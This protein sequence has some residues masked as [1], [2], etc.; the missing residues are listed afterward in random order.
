MR[1]LVAVPN[2]QPAFEWGGPV[3][4]DWNLFRAVA[5]EGVQ[6]TVV[7]SN[8]RPYGRVQRPIRH[9][10]EGVDIWRLPVIG[11]GRLPFATR[12]NVMPLMPPVLGWAL[13]RADLTHV[14]AVWGP[15]P[16]AAL[17]GAQLR[18][19]PA[20]VTPRGTLEQGSMT[21]RAGR[22]RLALAMGVGALLRGVSAYH[23]VSR[24]ELCASRGPLT[25]AA[26]AYVVPNPISLRPAK[27]RSPRSR[28]LTLGMFGRFHPVKGFDVILPALAKSERRDLRLVLAGPDEEGY[29]ATVE[30]LADCEGV[31]DLLDFRGMLEGDAL[32]EA[33]AQVDLLLLPSHHENFG[34]VVPEAAAQGTPAWVS[35]QVGIMDWVREED[36]GEVLPLSVGAWADKIARL[37]VTKLRRRYDPER[38]RAAVERHFAPESVARQMIRVYEEVLDEHR[39]LRAGD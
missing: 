39:R 22:K 29:R 5:Q 11:G 18:G 13:S 26:K 8:A 33:Y 37:D 3:R 19:L 23:F 6:V 1:L 35:D 4:S 15:T 14:P 36:T 38:L 24:R 32:Q 12:F 9:C 34:N 28:M 7:T 17:L 31:R 16:V 10:E 27:P 25:G 21:H 20:V 30:R 2:F